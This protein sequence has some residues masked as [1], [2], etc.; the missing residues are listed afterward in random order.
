MTAREARTATARE[1]MDGAMG[2]AAFQ[3][4]V[5]QLAELRGWRWYHSHDSR[6]DPAGFPDLVLV[7]GWVILFVELKS[8][9]GRL[10][11]EQEEWRNALLSATTH[12]VHVWRPSNWDIIEGEL[13]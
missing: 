12:H 4:A 11:P 5:L 13:L 1:V 2:E 6:R 8:E 9:R 10:R 3:A 7:R